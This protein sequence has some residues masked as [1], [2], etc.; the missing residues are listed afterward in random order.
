VRLIF[1]QTGV[2][3]TFDFTALLITLVTA[4]GLL[5]VANTLT[6][7]VMTKLLEQKDLYNWHTTEV[8]F[9]RDCVHFHLGCMCLC[10]LALMILPARALL[11][12]CAVVVPCKCCRVTHVHTPVP[13]SQV[14]EDVDKV[15][16]LPQE[17]FDA[18]MKMVKMQMQQGKGSFF[19]LDPDNNHLQKPTETEKTPLIGG[20]ESVYH[21]QE[22]SA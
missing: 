5:A 7:L 21:S 17:E 19:A 14:T 8:F 11:Y 3:G 13:Y 10:P 4:L 18:R 20:D 16:Q 15:L 6:N 9:S 12:N 2:I 22:A 1:I